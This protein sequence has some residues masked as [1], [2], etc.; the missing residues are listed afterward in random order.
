MARRFDKSKNSRKRKFQFYDKKERNKKTFQNKVT[1]AK[2]HVINLSSRKLT[3]N[4]YLL[5][6]RGLK[7]IPTPSIKFA[8]VKLM[9]DFDEFARKLRCRY[10]FQNQN[11]EELHPFRINSNYEPPFTCHTLEN[12]ISL[13]RFELSTN[14]DRQKC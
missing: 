11:S 1:K 3:D 14:A 6:A 7:F 10:L 5:L 8:K 2:E 9:R 13:T 4:E 12:Y